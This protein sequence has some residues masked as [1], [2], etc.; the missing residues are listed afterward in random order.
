MAAQRP[1]AP[2]AGLT[3]AAPRVGRDGALSLF[4]ERR[5]ARSVLAGCRW[6]MPL[7]VLAPMAFDD[8]AAIVS[9]LNPTGGL[10]GGDRLAIDV[11]VGAGA[12]AC[13]TTPSATKVYRTAA[14]PAEQTVRLTLGP[15]AR[16]EWVP[17]HTIPFAGAALRQRV[18]A[19]VA[20]GAALVLVDAFAA[21][22]VARGEAWRFALLDSALS[23]RD[24]GRWLLHDRLVLR[25]GA[26]CAGLGLAEDRRYVATVVV[27]ADTGIAAFADDVDAL[28]GSDDVDVGAALLPCRG[29]LVRC[30]AADAPALVRTV[31]AIWAAARRRVLGLPPLVLRKP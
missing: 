31:D 5:G 14:A 9:M 22:R 17:D 1:V 12:H 2:V 13:M 8:A 21:G 10:V 23:V 25:E 18:E 6:T 24:S 15:L 20:E 11:A 28:D 29:A 4:F 27:I 16:L 30:L 26:P 19:D 3:A 7:Q